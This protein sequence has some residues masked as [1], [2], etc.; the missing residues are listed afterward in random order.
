MRDPEEIASS[1]QA[2]GR[3]TAAARVGTRAAAGSATLRLSAPGWGCRHH[4]HHQHHQQSLPH[5]RRGEGG[6][7]PASG[8]MSF[9]AP[10]VDK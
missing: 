10:L 7:Q 5:H 8:P 6:V 1:Q 4:Q 9:V 3:E 2:S